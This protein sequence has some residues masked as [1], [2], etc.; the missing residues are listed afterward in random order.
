MLS[1]LRITHYTIILQKKDF[2][3]MDERRNQSQGICQKLFNFI[4]KILSSHAQKT[5]T[6]GPPTNQKSAEP[7][8]DEVGTKSDHPMAQVEPEKPNS[9]K[10]PN[11]SDNFIS[12]SFGSA[13]R[14]EEEADSVPNSAATQAK[15]PRKMVS[16]NDTVEDIHKILKKRKKNKSFEKLNSLENDEEETKP[17]RSILKVGSNLNE[18]TEVY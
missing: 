1:P 9:P 2:K 13:K 12:S 3:Q 8:H 5:I 7:N 14:E 18:K 10:N 16:M 4:M 15:A 17:L 6:L 11:P